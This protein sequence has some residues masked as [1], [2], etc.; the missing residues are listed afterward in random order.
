[1]GC[2]EGEDCAIAGRLPFANTLA[3][4]IWVS[5]E[6]PATTFPAKG[7]WS[8]W[9]ARTAA[10]GRDRRSCTRYEIM[11]L[12]RIWG[13][14]GVCLSVCVALCIWVTMYSFLTLD[15]LMHLCDLSV[16]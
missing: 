12:D 4:S 8:S 16:L 1:M 2:D 7:P 14:S 13:G 15:L 6:Q 10:V 5:L 3:P 9:E 11:E